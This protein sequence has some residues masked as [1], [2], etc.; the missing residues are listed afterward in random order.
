MVAVP[1]GSSCTMN[2]IPSAR[3]VA[4][5]VVM[6]KVNVVSKP[7]ATGRRFWCQNSPV[8]LMPPTDVSRIAAFACAV[9]P[10]S[11]SPA[12]ELKF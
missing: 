8:W 11:E 1:S 12:V 9:D 2:A 7:F 5:G 3:A 6:R 4:E 10:S